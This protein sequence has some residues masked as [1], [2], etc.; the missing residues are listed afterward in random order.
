MEKGEG[1]VEGMEGMVEE[2]KEEGGWRG[3]HI[4]DEIEREKHITSNT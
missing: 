1:G 4:G 2:V 3:R